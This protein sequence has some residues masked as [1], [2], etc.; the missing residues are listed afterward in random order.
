MARNCYVSLI[1]PI[2]HRNSWGTNVW[3]THFCSERT[4]LLLESSSLWRHRRTDATNRSKERLLQ[5]WKYQT[6]AWNNGNHPFL[7]RMLAR[8][9]D[10]YSHF[11]LWIRRRNKLIWR[12]WLIINSGHQKWHWEGKEGSCLEKHRL[13]SNHAPS[14]IGYRCEGMRGIEWIDGYSMKER[15]KRVIQCPYHASKQ[16]TLELKNGWE[17]IVI[18]QL[19]KMESLKRWAFSEQIIDD[20]EVILKFTRKLSK[21]LVNTSSGWRRKE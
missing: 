3:Q 7:S 21:W 9:I 13:I 4:L 11:E 18:Q 17:E 19:A 14:L 1:L 2:I 5:G 8:R 15:E 20:F 10:D 6:R 16:S 12:M